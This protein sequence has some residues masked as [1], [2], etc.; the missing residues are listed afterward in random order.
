M[1]K[2]LLS[3]IAATLAF[4]ACSKEEPVVNPEPKPEPPVEEVVDFVIEIDESTLCA[5]SVTFSVYPNDKNAIYYCDV[6]S[7]NRWEQTD[8]KDVIKELDESL[9]SFAQMTDSTYDEVVEQML[10]K[11]DNA[12][13]CSNA[14]YRGEVDY[15][16]YA[17]YWDVENTDPKVTTAEF[18]TPAAIES[19]ED[20]AI[21]FSN[22]ETTTM[23]VNYLPSSGVVE[24]YYYFNES[25]K[26]DD[27]LASLEDDIAYISYH[28]MNMGTKQT[29]AATKQETGL[30]AETEYTALVVLIDKDGNRRQIAATQKTPA[31]AT[32][33]RIESELFES[34]LGEWQG[35]Q[36]I[37]DGYNEPYMSTFGVT[38]TNSVEGY[39][40]DYREHNQ[41]V[42]LVDGWGN[43]DYYGINELNE[44]VED[45][46]D[47]EEKFGPKWTLNIGEGDVV[48]IDGKARSSVLGWMFM[49]HCFMVSGSTDGTTLTYDQDMTVT[50][51]EDG[52][53][54]TIASPA[55]RC[56]PSLAYDF[57]GFG[58]MGYFFGQSDITLTR[59]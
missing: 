18:R 45:M 3:L 9:K 30:K 28:A 59:L 26:V 25:T 47:A 39:N 16:I 29:E 35:K 8:V 33:N 49:G 53:T 4:A 46:E 7:K 31:V 57:V 1:K 36:L 15:V 12:D 55:S 17:F 43:I 20:V 50:V 56:Y 21:S 14:G 19:K 2:Y 27:M 41:L 52:N 6:M 44:M 42:A 13:V 54:L 22:I 24:Y 32:S 5:Y 38:I 23:S 37:F 48:T 58:W 51:S 10:N 11:G 40:Y 34:L